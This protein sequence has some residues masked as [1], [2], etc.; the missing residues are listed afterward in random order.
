M[1]YA[2]IYILNIFCLLVNIAGFHEVQNTIIQLRN[3]WA[4]VCI[5]WIIENIIFKSR[6]NSIWRVF[7]SFHWTN[8]ILNKWSKLKKMRHKKK[9]SEFW[10]LVVWTSSP[11]LPVV[12]KGDLTVRLGVPFAGLRRTLV[13]VSMVSYVKIIEKLP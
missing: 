2:N 10:S 9:D 12:L 5:G 3:Y 11:G 4:S 8:E 6:K 1:N 13:T 7:Y